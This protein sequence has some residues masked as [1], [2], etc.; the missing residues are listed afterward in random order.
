MKKTVFVLIFIFCVSLI[1]SSNT[2][3][4][5]FV[6]L[7]SK[8]NDGHWAE[9]STETLKALGVMNGYDG[10]SKP[11][12]I[13]TRG[14]F[15]ALV[16]RAFGLADNP[17]AQVFKDVSKDNI[18]FNNINA[19]HDA[20]LIDGFPDKTF[21]PANMV[22]REEIMLMLSRLTA[23]SA[24]N[25]KVNFTDID[26][27]YKYI[28]QLSKITS[29][30]IINGYPDGSFRPYAKT[31][32]AEAASMILSAMNKYMA[33]AS[34]NEALNVAQNFLSNHFSN[35]H[36]D[37]TGSALND[38]KY[39]K[40]TYEKAKALG[41]TVEN[42]MTNLNFETF[43]QKGPFTTLNAS[44]TVKRSINGVPKVY[45][46]KS[47][48]KLITQKNTTKVFEHNSQIIKSGPINLTWEVYTQPPK[49]ETAGVN[50]VSPT[51]FRVS[52]SQRSANAVD[53][54]HTES[55]QTLYF[56]S[57]LNDNYVSYAR[58]NNYEIWAMY[59]TDFETNTASVFLNSHAAR[60]QAADYLT[61]YILKYSLDGIN[62]D[63]EN[64]YSTDRGAYTNHVKE[65]TLMAHTLGA[66]VSV[67]VNKYEPTS[68]N[69]SMCYDRDKLSEIADYIAL[70]AYDQYYAGGKT[71]GPV[72]GLDWAEKCI[73]LTLSEVENQKLILG[74]PYYVRCW[75]IKNGKA[76]SSEAVSMMTAQK[77][78]EENSAAAEYD[79]KHSL[80]KYSWE[81]DG[82][83]YVLWL[84]NAESIRARVKLAKKHNLAGVASW[85]RGFE[86]ADVWT[87]IKDEL[88]GNFNIS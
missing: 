9:D 59:K 82:K 22:T 10:Y 35:V 11:D 37:I 66:T 57:S 84:E 80:I 30:G 13:I 45:S 19:A 64:M 20:G 53:G 78:I 8:D 39:I 32:R 36:N 54:L 70:M 61:E 34:T 52:N 79:S 7:T 31:T 88:F 18:F 41:Y 28:N 75:Q 17:G 83:S 43:E 85:R 40:Y 48:I 29:D 72:S 69:W 63:F 16:T 21:R 4:F 14:E 3:A 68:L 12:D 51:C 25:Q 27:Q 71:A 73:T 50:V 86:T 2:L 33:T 60:K 38:S 58:A 76:V 81:K 65:I 74:M 62:F 49:Y 77:Y 56:N 67:D 42:Q 24:A 6:T 15:A 1:T 87:A 47:Q 55:G 26:S 44:Y 23:G 46:G 5:D